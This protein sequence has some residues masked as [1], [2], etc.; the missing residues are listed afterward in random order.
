[1]WEILDT[2]SQKVLLEDVNS[3]VD[4]STRRAT[5]SRQ[6]S[7]RGDILFPVLQQLL[8]TATYQIVFID[9]TTVMLYVRVLFYKT[10][11]LLMNVSLDCCHTNLTESSRVDSS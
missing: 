11:F 3:S 1:M 6:R 4:V 8:P 10:N 7:G 5:G 9:S 2:L